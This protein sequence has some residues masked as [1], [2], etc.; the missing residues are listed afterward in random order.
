[1]SEGGNVAEVETVEKVDVGHHAVDARGPR[2][3]AAAPA[4]GTLHGVNLSGWL[5]L[6]SWVTPSLFAGTGALDE[7]SLAAAMGSQRFSE[8]LTAHRDTFITVQDFVNIAARGFDS[9]RLKIPWFVFGNAGPM[10]SPSSACLNYVDRAFDWAE[11][12]GLSILLDIALMPGVDSSSPGSFFGD[13]EPLRS[14]VLDVVSGLASRYKNRSSFLGIEPIDEARC[15]VR[16]GLSVSEGVPPHLLRNFYR[17]A[18]EV[19]RAAAGPKPVVVV[20]DGGTP[21]AWRAFMAPRRYKNVW[22]D[23]HLFHYAEPMSASGPIGVRQ[24]VRDSTS[25]LAKAR[26]SGLSV[27]VGEWS[28]ALPLSDASMT[29]EGRVALERIYLAGQM[30]AFAGGAAWFFQTWK[31]EGRLSSWDARVALSS[32]ER[33][34]FD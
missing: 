19:V 10:P 14:A 31:T 20:H 1:M 23:C 30:S 33:G 11:G 15:C 22:L 16:H 9:V 27:M 4:S 25:Y 21:S 2:H 26:R 32:F 6:E 17:D 5:V 12:V 34:M 3:R 18:Y 29:P 28:A 13:V 24:L 8:M 7:P